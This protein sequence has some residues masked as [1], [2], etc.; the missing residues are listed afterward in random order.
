MKK[1]LFALLSIV[2]ISLANKAFA[3]ADT[4]TNKPKK[5]HTITISNNGVFISGGDST[6]KAEKEIKKENKKF[7][8][9]Y[10]LFDLGVNK[11]IDNTNYAAPSVKE[12]LNVPANRQNKSLF[13]LV[14]PK[15]IDVNIYPWMIKFKALKTH[16][17]R[18]YI[19]SG[20][21]LQ[22]YNFR[23]EDPITYTRNPTGIIIDTTKS[24]KKNKLALNYLNIPLMFT[25]K[26]RLG[27]DTWLVYG[28]GA[29]AGVRLSSWTKQE[30]SQF[31]KVK[32][33]DQFG[34]ND[35]NTCLSAEI[36]LEG[37]FRLYATYQVTSLF[38]NGLDQHPI[39]IGLRFGG[40]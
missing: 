31:G 14:G 37:I 11:I 10:C 25:F 4:T 9:S 18:I 27:K 20:I 32:V 19:S 28:V 35:Y 8:M 33:Y 16:G 23:Y 1:I 29:T 17:Q 34:L 40:I 36:G 38:Q 15:A 26:T 5:H 22:L 24:Y 21:G 3:Q 12:F 13:D 30:S 7:T 2:S 6:S 39:C